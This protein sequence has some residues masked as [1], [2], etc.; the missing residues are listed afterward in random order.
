MSASDVRDGQVAIPEGYAAVPVGADQAE[1]TL[2]ICVLVRR[3]PDPVAGHLVVL[4]DLIDGRVLLGCILDAGGGAQ[5]WIELWVQDIEGLSGT[6]TACREALSNR[7]LDERWGDYFRSLGEAD[8]ASVIRTGWE[9]E[10]PLPTYVDLGAMEPVHPVDPQSGEKWQ[11]CRDDALLGRKGLPAYSTSLHRYV[12]LSALGEESPFIPTTSDAPRNESVLSPTEITGGRRGLLPLNAGGALLLVRRHCP[13]RLEPFVSVLSGGSWDGVFHGRTMMDLGATSEALK[14]ND[15]DLTAGGWMF[16]GRHGRWGRLVESFHLKLRLIADGLRAVRR[17][18][19]LTQRPL[20]NLSADSFQV[21]LSAP[22][23]GLPFLWTARAV[24]SNPGEAVTLPIQTSSA[25]YFLRAGA[26]GAS[27]YRPVS[28]VQ[29]VRGRGTV[30]IRQVLPEAGGATIVEGTFATQERFEAARYDL[31]WLR[32]NLTCGRVDLY[33]QLE[34]ASALAAGEWRFRTIGQRF[35]EDVLSALRSAEGVPVAETHFE[36][37]PL[38]SSPCDLYALAVLALRTLLVNVRT[39]LPVALDEMLSLARQV[40]EEHDESVGLGL[41][42]R[43]IFEADGR[44]A[45]ALG[46]QRLT[47]EEIGPDEAFDL[48]P[49]EVWFDTL[50]MIVRLLPGM[51]PDSLAKDF[52]DAPPG[53]IHKVFDAAIDDADDLLLRTRSLIVID[54]RFNREVHAVVRRHLMGL[55]DGT[56]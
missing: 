9:T 19:E 8:P 47:N 53:G 14:N 44:W 23:S 12:Y 35:G 7:V 52:G 33:G 3:E 46:P 40:A 32:M 55:G 54:W 6:A 1:S 29:P 2:R 41:R 18:A 17:V 37:I 26:E 22:A 28:A 25:Q 38:L 56:P 39:T 49:A 20:L 4:R 11:L 45:K 16:L 36:I 48:I 31:V 5:E 24:L 10:H 43:T 42:I 30:R 34:Q 13:I 27:V 50:A 21:R 15:P 51:G